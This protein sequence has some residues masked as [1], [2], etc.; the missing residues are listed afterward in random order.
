LIKK[1]L[2]KEISI[3]PLISFRVLF[4]FLMS[5]SIGRFYA[6]GW[7]EECYV[8]PTYFFS[9]YGF[10]WLPT[11]SVEG[12][13]LIYFL[14]FIFSLGIAFGA[15]YRISSIGFF[16]LFTYV[17][18]IDKTYYLNHYYFV[19][20]IAFLLIWVPANQA[21]SIDSKLWPSIK[22]KIV[23]AW[24][25]NIFKLQLAIV[26]FFAGIAKLQS[27]WLLN[28]MPLKIWLPAKSNT[29]I[30]GSLLQ[31]EWIAYAFSWGGAI[32][33]LTIVFFLLYAP[34]RILAFAA[35]IVF[36]L[37]TAALFQIGMFPYIMIIASLIFFSAEW[38]EKIHA[39]FTNKTRVNNDVGTSKS[40][41]F[42]KPI[43][44]ILGVFLIMQI[45]LPVRH[46]AYPGNLFWTEQGYR[47]SWRVMLMEKTAFTTFIVKDSKSEKVDFVDNTKY[48][49]P[50]QEKMMSTQPDMILQFA[51]YIGQQYEE[52]GFEQVEVY[53]NSKLSLNGRR[54]KIYIDPKVDLMKEQRGFN[55]KKWIV[56]E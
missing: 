43:L 31:E 41:V 26:Y 12:I 39:Y 40:L 21:F 56:E 23:P 35:V 7:I 22:A 27:D 36:H 44:S 2:Y 49:K 25:I 10:D 5:F 42:Q 55:H 29:P 1:W 50:Q 28:A 4:G 37:L 9:Y 38:H 3:A 18:L 53:C 24:S 16:L 11:P 33:D 51:H 48:L 6:K 8:K 34:T 30:I 15:L 20:I 54:S 47:F 32:Y 45:L 19:S 13:Y 46:L 17:E 52:K 14:L